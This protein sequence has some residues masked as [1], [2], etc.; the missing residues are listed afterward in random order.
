MIAVAGLAGMAFASVGISSAAADSSIRRPRPPQFSVSSTGTWTLRDYGDAVVNGEGE[1]VRRGAPRRPL[2]VDVAA[3][4]SPD[5]RTLPEPD[6]CEGAI[7]TISV[8]GN[9]KV[10][11]MTLIGYG[12]VCGVHPQLPTSVVTHVFTGTYE[13]LEGARKLVGTDGFFEVR[14]GV[15]GSAS[16]FAIDT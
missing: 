11:D 4:I 13:V 12:E 16:A 5:D 1:L 7:A 2:A 14:L 9:R 8:Y 3:V 6:T 10:R 15:D